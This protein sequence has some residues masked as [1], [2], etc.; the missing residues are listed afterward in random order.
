VNDVL[1]PG[2][3]PETPFGGSGASGYGRTRGEAGLREM[4]RPRVADDGPPD[5]VPRRHLLPYRPGTLSILSAL[6]EREAASGTLERLR[7]VGRVYGA[8]HRF[9]KGEA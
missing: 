1:L 4:V 7:A 6:T 3:D 5:W 8:V 9:R 2:A